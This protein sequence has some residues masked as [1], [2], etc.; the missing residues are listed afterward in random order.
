MFLVSRKAK[1]NPNSR[2]DDWNNNWKMIIMLLRLYRAAYIYDT[3]WCCFGVKYSHCVMETISD[4]KNY[5]IIQ[6]YSLIWAEN[7]TGRN[8]T[9]C[10][11]AKQTHLESKKYKFWSFPKAISSNEGRNFETS[12]LTLPIHEFEVKSWW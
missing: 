9:T 3:W 7:Y 5:D 1:K 11:F 4:I 6:L 12:N 2:S 10:P 8:P